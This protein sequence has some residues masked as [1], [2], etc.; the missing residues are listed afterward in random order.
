M[1]SPSS[2]CCWCKTDTQTLVGRTLTIVGNECAETIRIW[3]QPQPYTAYRGCV[4]YQTFYLKQKYSVDQSERNRFG[5]F[6]VAH[7]SLSNRTKLHIHRVIVY[8]NSI[9]SL[10]KFTDTYELMQRI[11]TK[12][13]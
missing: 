10:K 7:R 5:C 13:Y 8:V 1:L 9:N 4:F 6:S 11:K 3:I 12:I 2:M